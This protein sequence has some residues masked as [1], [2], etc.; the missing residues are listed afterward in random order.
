[1]SHLWCDSVHVPTHE[2]DPDAV[3]A[4][5]ASILES[6]G[7]VRADRLCR[8]LRFTVEAKL[9]GEADQIKEYVLGREVFDRNGDYDPRVDSIVRVEAR[10][11]RARLEE[12]YS[13]TGQTDT[14]RIEFPKGSYIPVIRHT[15]ELATPR[16]FPWKRVAL[17]ISGL[18]VAIALVGYGL[19]QPSRSELVAVAPAGWLWGES[20][21]APA[22]EESLAEKVGIELANRHVARVIGWP[23]MLR[24]RTGRPEFRQM[25]AGVGATKVLLIRRADSGVGVFLLSA[26]SGE[27][28][29]VGEYK[30]LGNERALVQSIVSDFVTMYRR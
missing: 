15:G 5:L 21:D 4:H 30:T 23:L 29:C 28:I 19:W 7:F 20:A 18:L 6:T 17:W 27:K 22:L 3:R 12:Y 13:A 25:A 11:L 24:Y 1:M 14:L 26:A 8:F 10:R 2:P 16:L 9:N